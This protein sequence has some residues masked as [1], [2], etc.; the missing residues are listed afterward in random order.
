MSTARRIASEATLQGNGYAPEVTADVPS[1]L[2]DR[3]AF[4]ALTD[5]DGRPGRV[6]TGA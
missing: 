3:T 4:L 6:L 2:P 1:P 5:P